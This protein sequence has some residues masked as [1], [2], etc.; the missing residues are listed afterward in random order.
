MSPPA[1]VFTRDLSVPFAAPRW[2]D[3]SVRR[4]FTAETAPAAHAVLRQAY[5]NGLGEVGTYA[6]WY[7][8]LVADAEYDPDLCF[9]YG[10]S[11]VAFGFAQVWT[12]GFVKDI[13]VAESHRRQGIGK[14]LLA[15]VF[16][17]LQDRG[18]A[19]VRLKVVP[20]NENAIALYRTCGMREG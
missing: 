4:P 16:A 9:L 17:E 12:S 7:D 5:A 10:S 11:G 3:G 14:A 6:D 15:T 20:G 2:P 18:L 13:A 1:L 8:A 19:E